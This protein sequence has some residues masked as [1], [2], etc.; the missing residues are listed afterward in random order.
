MKMYTLFVNLALAL[1]MATASTLP[2]SAAT[3]QSRAAVARLDR[4]VDKA[5][6]EGGPFFTPRERAVIERSCGYAPGTWDGYQVN[7][8]G[9]VFYCTNGRRVHLRRFGQ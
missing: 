2:A 8:I 1:S 5:I 3:A 9:R 6:D 7:M 4:L